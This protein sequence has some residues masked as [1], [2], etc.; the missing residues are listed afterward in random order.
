MTSQEISVK[1]KQEVTEEQTRPGRVYQPDVDIYETKESLW[2]EADMPGVDERT[3]Q[4]NLNDG[5]LTIEGE[6]SLEDYQSI[7]PVYS[8]YRVGHYRR[9]FSVSSDIDGERIQGKLTHGVL[10]LELPKAE[11]AK[12]RQIQVALG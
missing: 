9:R 2:L 11:K 12:P 5:V 4:V 3:V 1:P 8:E 10:H 7:S 6:V